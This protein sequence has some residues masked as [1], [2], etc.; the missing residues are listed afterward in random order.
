MKPLAAVGL[1]LMLGAPAHAA[2]SGRAEVD[3]AGERYKRPYTVE[4]T[5]VATDAVQG[6]ITFRTRS[7]D[8]KTARVGPDAA[9]DLGRLRPGQRVILV[10]RDAEATDTTIV[11]GLRKKGSAWKR[12]ALSAAVILLAIFPK[13][14]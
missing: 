6:T 11:D 12:V 13:A 3:P 4:A 14:Y 10:C 5:V 2:A 9:G 1:S 7:N 8:L